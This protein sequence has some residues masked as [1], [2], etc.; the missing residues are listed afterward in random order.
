M[1]KH[2]TP[3]RKTRLMLTEVE[4]CG[5]LGQAE[6]G[7]TLEYY[8]GFLAVDTVLHGC[9]LSE[10]DRIELGQI[11]RRALWASERGL[12]HLLQRRHGPD[13]YSYYIIVRPKRPSLPWSELLAAEVS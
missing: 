8:R 4:L 10:R 9:R 3:P 5:W 2:V 6:P 1:T 13:D 12:A 11:A 7:D